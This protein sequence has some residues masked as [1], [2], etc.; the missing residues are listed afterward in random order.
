MSSSKANSFT[1]YREV[2]CDQVIWNEDSLN[3]ELVSKV[4]LANLSLRQ[5]VQGSVGSI[6][7]AAGTVNTSPADLCPG[8]R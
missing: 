3:E 4:K 1:S 5:D 6:S 2:Y 8:W 7:L